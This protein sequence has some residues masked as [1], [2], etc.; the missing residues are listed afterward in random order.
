MPRNLIANY[1]QHHLIAANRSRSINTYPK[2][3]DRPE[4]SVF[5]FSP[6]TFARINIHQQWN[7]LM[8]KIQWHQH[9]R[10]NYRH[11]DRHCTDNTPYLCPLLHAILGTI[12]IQRR[13]LRRADKIEKWKICQF[14]TFVNRALMTTENVITLQLHDC[15]VHIDEMFGAAKSG[16]SVISIREQDLLILL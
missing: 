2:T 4:H 7:P 6:M 10:H 11:S 9:Q 3:R 15:T 16:A 8:P 14:Y 1:I 13:L 12:C 5:S